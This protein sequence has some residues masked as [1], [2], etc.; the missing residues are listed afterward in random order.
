MKF[1]L[2]S[3]RTYAT[4]DLC[5]VGFVGFGLMGLM[6]RRTYGPSDLWGRRTCEVDPKVSAK[7]TK[8]VAI[9]TIKYIS[10]KIPFIMFL[11]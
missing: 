5:N 4:S 9:V 10:I 3:L 7:S 2:V 1:G 11:K 6:G 8:C